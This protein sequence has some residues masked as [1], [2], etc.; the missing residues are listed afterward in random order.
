[1]QPNSNVM[2]QDYSFEYKDENTV[3][4]SYES[5]GQKREFVRMHVMSEKEYNLY[6][7]VTKD[8]FNTSDSK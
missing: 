3:S 4:V 8:V 1:M 7:E 5:N 6:V 2:S